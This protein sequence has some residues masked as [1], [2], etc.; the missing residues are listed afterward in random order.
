MPAIACM[1]K[2]TGETTDRGEN[3][4]DAIAAQLRAFFGVK[5]A[6]PSK[7]FGVETATAA[8]AGEKWLRFSR[9]PALRCCA[10]AAR[11]VVPSTR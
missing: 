1:A 4:V 7:V 10:R 8:S 5:L 3:T 6:E 2:L 11:I 9:P